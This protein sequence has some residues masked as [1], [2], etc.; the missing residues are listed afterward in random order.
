M[1]HE[2]ARSKMLPEQPVR[3]L[4]FV[5]RRKSARRIQNPDEVEAELRVFAEAWLLS[6]RSVYLETLQPL[7]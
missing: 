4:T 6:L 2:R 7:S 5:R 3:Y 1:L